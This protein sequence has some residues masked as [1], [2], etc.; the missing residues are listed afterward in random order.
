MKYIYYIIGF[1]II[2]S[3]LAVYGLFNT[4]VEISKPVLSI[5]DRIISKAELE[6]MMTGQAHQMTRKMFIESIIDK[7]LLIQEAVKNN[8]HMEESFRR[9]VE[10]FYEQSLISVLLDRKFKSLIVDVTNDEIAKYEQLMKNRLFLTKMIYPSMQD[11]QN[12][13]NETIQ[14]IELNFIDLSDDLKFIVLNLEKGE[15]SQPETTYFGVLIYRL[16]DIQEIKKPGIGDV[17]EFDIKRV[18]LYIQD[19]KKEALMEE[20]TDK[21]REN[22]EIWRGDE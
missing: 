10:N 19:K 9:S 13:T 4:R 12:H 1:M 17:E 5:N 7:Q 20:W 8:I 6:K 16:D 2:F 3:G 14:K 15:L 11:A 21:I 18:S 22:A